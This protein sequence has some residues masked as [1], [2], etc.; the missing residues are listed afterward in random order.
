MA[1]AI[2]TSNP[3]EPSSNAHLHLGKCANIFGGQKGVDFLQTE[4]NLLYMPFSGP[5][6]DT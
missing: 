4:S 1:S 3:T 6:Y 5:R 2:H